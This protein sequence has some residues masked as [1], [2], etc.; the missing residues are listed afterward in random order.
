[1]FVDTD[2]L[3]MGAD[4]SKS[5][6]EIAM[7]GAERFASTSLP[8]GIFGDFDAAHGFHSALGRAHEAQAATMRA[9]HANFDGLAAKANVGAA[10]FET[11]D[12]A[13]AATVRSAG[14]NIT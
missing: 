7:R 1:M 10:E 2:L 8:A 3:R 12:E 6:G 5:A 4:F 11:Q 14:E 9:H 13:C